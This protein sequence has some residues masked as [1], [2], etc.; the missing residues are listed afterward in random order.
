MVVACVS[1][2]FNVA[3]N[4]SSKVEHSVSS[5]NTLRLWYTVL[6]SLLALIGPSKHGQHA[7]YI[8]IFWFLAQKQLTMHCNIAL[9][10]LSLVMRP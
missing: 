3:F 2:C 6:C 9:P 1:S 4:S 10:C 7:M 8:V 5:S